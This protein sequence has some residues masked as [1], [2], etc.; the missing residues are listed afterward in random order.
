MSIEMKK[1]ILPDPDGNEQEFEI[2]D[3][4]MREMFITPQMFGAKGDGESDDTE[5]LQNLFEEASATGETV[6]FPNGTY[7]ITDTVNITSNYYMADNAIIKVNSSSTLEYALLFSQSQEINRDKIGECFIN[8]DCNFKANYGIGS[9]II[10]RKTLTLRINNPL[11]CGFND[12]YVNNSNNENIINCFVSVAKGH[13]A[14]YGVITTVDNYYNV[15]TTVNCVYGIHNTSTGIYINY[16]HA[17]SWTDDA[18][19]M[20]DSAVIKTDSSVTVGYV[21]Q[22]TMKYAIYSEDR[23][24]NV[25]ITSLFVNVPN[26]Y[27]YEIYKITGN[28]GQGIVDIGYYHNQAGRVIN[29]TLLN[30]IIFNVGN[31]HTNNFT[32]FPCNDLNDLPDSGT[33]YISADTNTS[34]LPSDITVPASINVMTYTESYIGIQMLFTSDSVYFRRYRVDNRTY[35]SWIKVNT[36]VYKAISSWQN[37]VAAGDTKEVSFN[38]GSENFTNIQATIYGNSKVICGVTSYTGGVAKVTCYNA[39]QYSCSFRVYLR[40]E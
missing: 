17:W 23:K 22:D 14:T 3:G 20:G 5:A 27:N 29:Y 30:G 26:N 15:I 32:G 31:L 1:L 9:G 2:V 33:F 16:V 37:D 38:T 4:K 39:G 8:L 24:I 7:C 19:A 35:N 21:Y 11:V 28:N 10:A 12:N 34:N 40:A 36:K 18:V 25:K 13:V 6:V